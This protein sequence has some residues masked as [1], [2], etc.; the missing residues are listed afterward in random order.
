MYS[1]GL[2]GSP[3]AKRRDPDGTEV[4]L[5][6]RLRRSFQ[7][8]AYLAAS[9]GFEAGR[10]DLMEAVWPTEGER[11]IEVAALERLGCVLELGSATHRSALSAGG[12]AAVNWR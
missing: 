1:L 10:E 4:D 5:D 12:R 9:P 8:L 6:C 3:F 2:L 11:T 7:V